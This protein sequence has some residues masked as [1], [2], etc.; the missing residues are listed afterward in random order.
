MSDFAVMPS[1]FG[2][3]VYLMVWEGGDV[4]K[5]AGVKKKSLR[6]AIFA[7]YLELFYSIQNFLL[8]KPTLSK[9]Q[10]FNN[11]SSGKIL[12]YVAFLIT[13]FMACFLWFMFVLL[14]DL[15]VSTLHFSILKKGI[16]AYF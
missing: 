3:G 4:L 5:E 8:G 1:L 6:S 10:P 15:A 2:I 7:N 9:L 13:C 16:K 11:S 14:K 12:V